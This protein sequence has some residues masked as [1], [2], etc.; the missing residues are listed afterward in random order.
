M[1]NVPLRR[2]VE[3]GATRI[4]VLLCASPV[5]TPTSPRRPVEALLNAFFIS[6]HA[7]FARDIAQLP[8]GVEVILCVGSESSARD[9]DDFSTT[10]SL[11][12]QGRAEASEVVRRWGL[13]TPQPAPATT[14]DEA[15]AAV[16]DGQSAASPPTGEPVS[17]GGETDTQ[18]EPGT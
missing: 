13:G 3:G 14:R 18:P 8:P 12:A 5:Y 6:V 15:V 11:I 16:A 1:N 10:E 4:V 17:V 7:R 2:A 9:F